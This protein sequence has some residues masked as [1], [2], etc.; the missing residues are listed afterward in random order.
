MASLGPGEWRDAI[1]ALHPG[2]LMFLR[3]AQVCSAG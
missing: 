1:T 3:S 2:A